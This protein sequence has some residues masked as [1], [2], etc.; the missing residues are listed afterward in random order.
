M[1]PKTGSFVFLF[2]VVV[3][4]TWSGATEVVRV[5]EVTEVTKVVRST[6]VTEV[7]RS[8]EVYRS[9]EVTELTSFN[10]YV[11]IRSVRIRLIL[12]GSYGGMKRLDYRSSINYSVTYRIRSQYR[13]VFDP[14][15]IRQ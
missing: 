14:S 8:T 7:V 9:T 6:G 1:R 4:T 11:R 13:T 15:R 5:T 10:K 3:P 2:S 12:S